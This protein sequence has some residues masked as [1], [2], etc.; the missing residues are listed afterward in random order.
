[1]HALSY[2]NDSFN[3]KEPF[4]GLFT[5]GMVCHETYKDQNNNWVSPDELVTKDG[6]KY[7]K[8]SD[9]LVKVGPSE[10]MSKSKKN[11]ID[12]EKI[13]K[14]YGADS[15]R[16]FILS[17]SPPEKDVQWSDEGIKSSYKFLQ[18][19]WVLNQ[20]IIDEIEANHS[21]NSNND[22]DKLT[23]KFIK[24]ITH[25]IEN[26]S[27]NKII[28]NLHETYSALNK[29][30]SSKIEK[31]KLIENYKKILVAISPVIPHFSSE[32][33]EI[34]DIKE[35]LLWPKVDAKFLEEDN[36]KFIIQFNGKTRKIIEL[37]KDTNE[38]TLIKKIKED[39]KLNEYLGDNKILKKIFIA[40]KLINIII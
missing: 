14:D 5:Q 7:L 26:F 22:L 39:K 4:S 38:E 8:D 36:I 18:K 25:N 33:M 27:Y 31:S 40:N 37:K 12:P 9:E 15:V 11:T 24:E 35:K 3:I 10:S 30:I 21:S 17:D 23:N 2:Q 6:K 1:M 16:L 28:A 20:K 13:I 19:L 29:I 32:C 34:L